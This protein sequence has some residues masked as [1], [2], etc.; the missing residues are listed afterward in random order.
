MPENLDDG[1][2]IILSPL[3][4]KTLSLSSVAATHTLLPFVHYHHPRLAGTPLPPQP[5]VV[6]CTPLP[7]ACYGGHLL[8]MAPFGS[9]AHP[10]HLHERS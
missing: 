4:L 5:I 6:T 9:L 1:T 10:S 2:Y 3:N 7:Y 8:G